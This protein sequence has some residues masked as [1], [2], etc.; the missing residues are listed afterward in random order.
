MNITDH[1]KQKVALIDKQV[2]LLQDKGASDVAALD[3]LMDF[4]PD[5]SCIIHNIAPED[6]RG[7]LSK[8]SGFAS[9]ISKIERHA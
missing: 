7:L 1:E 5:A 9:F 2:L 3:L 4:V 8:Y 6:M